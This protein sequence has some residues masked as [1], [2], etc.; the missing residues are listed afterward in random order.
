MWRVFLRW[1]LSVAAGK[2]A[3]RIVDPRRW[4]SN[5]AAMARLCFAHAAGFSCNR[6]E[7]KMYGSMSKSPV[8][9]I[10]AA[11]TVMRSA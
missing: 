9:D 10:I 6:V 7:V 5:F 1:R 11:I 2:P 3:L 4:Y 8:L